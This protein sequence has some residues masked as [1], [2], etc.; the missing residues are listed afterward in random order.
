[1]AILKKAY[2]GIGYSLIKWNLPVARS[3]V[4]SNAGRI[5][6][7]VHRIKAIEDEF[8][9]LI[10]VTIPIN[11]LEGMAVS[12][13]KS[14]PVNGWA[15]LTPYRV[16]VQTGIRFAEIGT[17]DLPNVTHMPSQGKLFDML[18]SKRLDVVIADR[19]D[20]YHQTLRKQGKCIYIHEPPLTSAPLYHYLH[21]KHAALVPALTKILQNMRDSG[22]MDRIR[23]QATLEFRAKHK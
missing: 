15:S 7:E 8:P 1:M 18:F 11:I 20:A 3:L 6:G 22:E 5:D 19:Q 14:L 9:N 17:R 21:K 4:E 12:C 23:E 10:R 16:G 2:A 13:S